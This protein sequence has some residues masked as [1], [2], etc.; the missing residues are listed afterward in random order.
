MFSG[1]VLADVN[2]SAG[3][4][5][6][7]GAL[8]ASLGLAAGSITNVRMKEAATTTTGS[9]VVGNGNRRLLASSPGVEV[10]FE[11]Q[12]AQG[13]V[14]Q[15]STK[16]QST[17]ATVK[18]S[19]SAAV[20][21]SLTE[22]FPTK[23]FDAVGYEV[24]SLT[25]ATPALAGQPSPSTAGEPG[26]SGGGA[27]GA[28]GRQQSSGPRKAPLLNGPVLWISVGG[29]V[30]AVSA[31]VVCG[32]VFLRGCCRK[33]GRPAMMPGL[34]DDGPAD[35]SVLEGIELAGGPAGTGTGTGT[36]IGIG[37]GGGGG[38]GGGGGNAPPSAFNDLPS[39]TTNPMSPGRQDRRPGGLE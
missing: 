30:L 36:R 18:A 22:A 38:G 11:M 10:V 2:S 25:A 8:E 4:A 28:G 23:T 7:S 12:G 9:G 35:A 24:M 29:G 31:L 6:I 26:G 1:L 33:G 20:Q 14:S 34:V 21:T 17:D 19:I 15:A 16:L 37:T 3:A 5:A 32:I 13:A 39:M 27:G